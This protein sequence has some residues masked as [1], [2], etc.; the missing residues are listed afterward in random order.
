MKK[1]KVIPIGHN[2][3]IKPVPLKE[4]T[5]SG[6]ILPDSQ[7]QQIPKGTVV[8]KGGKVSNEFQIGD[9]IQWSMEH[10][11]AKEFEHE[12]EKHLLLAESGVVCKL[13]HLD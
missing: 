8:S 13:S 1:L 10:T 4:T 2:L 6:I 9:H 3:L 7:V 11:N 12:E 5:T